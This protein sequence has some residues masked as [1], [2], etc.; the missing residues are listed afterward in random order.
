MPTLAGL[1]LILALFPQPDIWCT[2]EGYR[3]GPTGLSILML[4]QFDPSELHRPEVARIKIGRK[5]EIE[6]C[7]KIKRR[8]ADIYLSARLSRR[9]RVVKT[10]DII[11]VT[12]EKKQIVVMK[13]D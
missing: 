8:E 13:G 4:G 1:A 7:R 12:R 5:Y 10:G 6:Y 11:I 9:G 3:I 2:T